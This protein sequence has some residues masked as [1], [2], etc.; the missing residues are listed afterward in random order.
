MSNSEIEVSSERFLEV[1]WEGMGPSI[2]K[3]LLGVRD[4]LAESL[5]G[6]TSKR[7]AH[8]D[9]S[10][11]A[12]MALASLAHRLGGPGADRV[13]DLLEELEALREEILPEGY[14]GMR[15]GKTPMSHAGFATWTIDQFLDERVTDVSVW[16]LMNAA[17]P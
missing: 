12:R 5:A 14:A 10:A 7:V 3:V 2:Q 8:G 9:L 1:M 17:R 6:E 4:H 16:Q 15:E 13:E 11:K